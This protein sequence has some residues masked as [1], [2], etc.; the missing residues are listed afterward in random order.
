MNHRCWWLIQTAEGLCRADHSG[1]E[2]RCGQQCPPERLW[3]LTRLRRNFLREKTEPFCPPLLLVHRLQPLQE[4]NV[5]GTRTSVCQPGAVG[6]GW[7]GS[8][9]AGSIWR[10]FRWRALVPPLTR[11]S[12]EWCSQHMNVCEVSKANTWVRSGFWSSHR[13][14][15]AYERDHLQISRFI[16]QFFKVIQNSALIFS[17][18]FLNVLHIMLSRSHLDLHHTPVHKW[19]QFSSKNTRSEQ[20]FT[21]VYRIHCQSLSCLLFLLCSLKYNRSGKIPEVQL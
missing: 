7:L 10:A 6:W 12:T 16:F 19:F 21:L 4:V 8:H 15:W 9:K 3:C 11:C 14:V 5:R 18:L 13:S 20:T 1:N 17:C 2:G